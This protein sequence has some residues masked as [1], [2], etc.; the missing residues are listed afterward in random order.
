M[1]LEPR[2]IEVLQQIG[3]LVIIIAIAV[4]IWKLLD[5]LADR[6]L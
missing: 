6:P 2:D 5:W 1:K 4:G 3:Q